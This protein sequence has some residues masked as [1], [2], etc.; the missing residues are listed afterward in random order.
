[1]SSTMSGCSPTTA[2]RFVESF[3]NHNTER[4]TR[5]TERGTVSYIS[6]SFCGMLLKPQRGT[7]N[8]ERGTVSYISYSFCGML[9]KPQRGTQNTEQ[10]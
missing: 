8:T 1:M 10:S 2:I 5:N 4:G 9:L 6:Y 3:S 7:R